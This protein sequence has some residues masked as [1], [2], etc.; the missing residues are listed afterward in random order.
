MRGDAVSGVRNSTLANSIAESTGRLAIPRERMSHF[1]R[2]GKAG[3]TCDL[4]LGNHDK[5]APL[6]RGK[7]FTRFI[8]VWRAP[9]ECAGPGF[10]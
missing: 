10:R 7:K 4:S 6:L 5:E 2:G 3:A 8:E 9:P 1:S